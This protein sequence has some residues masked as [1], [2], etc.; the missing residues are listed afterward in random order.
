MVSLMVN[1]AEVGVQT[2][3]DMRGFGETTY[4]LPLL[5]CKDI[6]EDI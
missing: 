2:A 4:K 3:V 5:D 1:N 6:A